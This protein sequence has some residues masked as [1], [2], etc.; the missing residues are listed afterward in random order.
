MKQTAFQTGDRVVLPP[1]GIGVICGTCLKPV[2]LET[3]PYYQIEFEH[4]SSRAYV[5]VRAP[6]STGMRPALT[7]TRLPEILSALQEGEMDLPRQWSARQQKVT[8][9]L[10]SGD[11]DEL[12]RMI[13]QFHRWNVRRTLPD[14]DRQAFRRAVKLLEA[15]VRDLHGKAAQTIRLFLERALLEPGTVN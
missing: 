15:E 4:T 9:V 5:P 8:A 13:G 11:P 1:Y 6:D 10:A 3:H 12:A 14:L 2:G 7:A